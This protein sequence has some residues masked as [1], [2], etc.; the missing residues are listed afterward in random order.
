MATALIALAVALA[1]LTAAVPARATFPGS[2]GKIAF[3]G[4][5]DHDVFTVN[6]DGSA[7]ANLTRHLSGPTRGIGWSPDGQ[8][9]AFNILG[10]GLFTM[11]ANGSNI[12]KIV[13]EPG[14]IVGVAWSPDGTKIAFGAYNPFSPAVLPYSIFLV[15]SD[16]SNRTRLT[17][18]GWRTDWSPNGKRI[19]FSGGSVFSGGYPDW[20]GISVMD[21]DGTNQRRLTT[22]G[23]SA[24]WSPDGSQIAF[25]SPGSA[26]DNPGSGADQ[27]IWVM[28]S[29]GSNQRAVTSG[30]SID[31]SPAWSPDGTKIAIQRNWQIWT[32]RPD[33][34][35]LKRIT[36]DSVG[37]VGT[38]MW[39]SIPS[40]EFKESCREQRESMGEAAFKA[41]YGTNTNGKN[42][43]GKCVSGTR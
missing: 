9:I 19:A 27:H 33:G 34:S 15:S 21:P 30:D 8:K 13:S 2:N 4:R 11:N 42:A 24:S 16:G 26:F 32:M 6:P 1:L 28:N 36:D 41:R 18:G 3:S 39:Q 12:K 31:Y 23:S 43:F 10:T 40:T 14:E 25:D 7:L 29:D 37:L 38:P 20:Y 22:F 17:R 35:E 5:P